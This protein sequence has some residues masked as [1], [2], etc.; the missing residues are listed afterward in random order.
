MIEWLE[1]IWLGQLVAENKVV[2][3]WL[4]CSFYEF[5]IRYKMFILKCKSLNFISRFLR[6]LASTM[7]SST[8]ASLARHQGSVERPLQSWPRRPWPGT[9]WPSRS[10]I[11][12]QGSCK[13]RDSSTGGLEVKSTSTSRTQSLLCKRPPSTDYLRPTPSTC[14][15]PWPQLETA[16]SEDGSTSRSPKTLLIFLR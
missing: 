13:I 6:L 4:H 8:S 11:A 15:P 7:R 14:R 9:R 10:G 5:L 1:K 16:P 3:V 12:T 2:R